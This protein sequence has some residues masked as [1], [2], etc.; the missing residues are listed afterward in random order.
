MNCGV[1]MERFLPGGLI[2]SF[3]TRPGRVGRHPFGRDGHFGSVVDP[4]STIS[5]G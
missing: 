3:R 1:D 5:D 2:V 4:G